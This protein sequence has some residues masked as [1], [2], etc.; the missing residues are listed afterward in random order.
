LNAGAFTFRLFPDCLNGRHA[1]CLG[2]RVGARRLESC[3]CDC[4]ETEETER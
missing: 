3:L 4:H 1:D 2:E